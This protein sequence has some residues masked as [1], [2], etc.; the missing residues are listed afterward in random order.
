MNNSRKYQGIKVHTTK[1]R[2]MYTVK[3]TGN[4]FLLLTT[5]RDTKGF[6][7]HV[8]QL[9][10]VAGG[11]HNDFMYHTKPHI[12][13]AFS[14][15]YPSINGKKLDIIID[16]LKDL[17]GKEEEQE[18]TVIKPYDPKTVLLTTKRDTDLPF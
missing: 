5:K 4:D 8:S 1:K 11:H 10:D 6:W 3:E 12:M 7:I 18:A 14:R 9:L 15:E 2:G 17:L 13:K 16:K